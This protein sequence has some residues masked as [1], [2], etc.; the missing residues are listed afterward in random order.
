MRSPELLSPWDLDGELPVALDQYGWR[1]LAEGD[2]WFS[3]GALNPFKSSNLLNHLEFARRSAV[4]NCAQPGDTLR[5]VAQMG[6]DPWFQHLWFGDRATRWDAILL[7]AGG[8][9]LIDAVQV[10]PAGAAAADPSLRLLLKPAEWGPASAGA[11]RFLSDAGWQR[12]S[13]YLRANFDEIVAMRDAEGSLSRGVPIFTHSYAVATPRDAPSGAH[14]PW[15][16]PAMRL[17]QLPV[18]EWINISRTLMLRLATLLAEIAADPV[19]YPNLH[20]FDSARLVDIEPAH[21]GDTGISGDWVNEI[22]LTRK[23]CAK[24]AQPWAR[25]IDAVLRAGG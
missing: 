11:A 22:H 3:I 25:R 12:F 9:D 2:S 21:L 13:N 7:S 19:R 5:H 15:L 1:F 4:V 17:Y 24:L 10:V 8:N 18:T 6:G 20:V 23:G 16:Y 14:G